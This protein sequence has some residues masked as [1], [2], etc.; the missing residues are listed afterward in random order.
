MRIGSL[1][2][3]ALRHRSWIPG[4]I[5]FCVLTLAL[6]ILFAVPAHGQTETVLYN[7][8]GQVNCSDGAT[9]SSSLTSDGKGN[10]YGTT[11]AG[12]IGYG[13]FFELSPNGNGGWN[14]DVLYSFSGGADGANPT[15][16]SLILDSGGNLYG[17]TVGGGASEDGLVFEMSPKGTNWAETVLYEFAGGTD[18]A[19]PGYGVIMDQAGNLY[20]TTYRGGGNGL[21]TVFELT[22]SGG[23][24]TEQVIYTE[25]QSSRYIY[26]SGLAL[27]GTGHLFGTT[28]LENSS[29]GG[30]VFE[31]T[32]NGEGGWNASV[33]Y[34][35][36]DHVQP[37]GTLAI[38]A[39]GNLYG[40]S[41]GEGE[42]THGMIYKLIPKKTGKWALQDLYPFEGYRKKEHDGANPVAGIVFD[43][44]G[45]IYGTTYAGGEYDKGTVFELVA[46]VGK[47]KYTEKILWSFNGT[48]GWGATYS[49]TLDNAGNLY[50]TTS[51]GG[52]T[53]S[54]QNGGDGV[55]FEVTP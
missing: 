42:I 31:L 9:P 54:D 18:G 6:S 53:Y 39:A 17:T 48:D 4:T 40:S 46:Q 44:A 10:F 24:W 16:S 45:N 22:P 30:T 23:G 38:D 7:F 51:A 50:G 1:M 15:E 5:T 26:P 37:A 49:L 19:N 33:I 34:T 29:G 27:D 52:T 8:C 21:G 28:S 35:F 11:Y 14:E 43:A 47:G 13:T 41:T 25:S 20:G 32:P 3:S 12:G 55:V 36:N 2:N